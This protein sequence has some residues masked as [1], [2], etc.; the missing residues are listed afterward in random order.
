MFTADADAAVTAAF[1]EH[2]K[3]MSCR[4]FETKM[5]AANRRCHNRFS[6]RFFS[7]LNETTFLR[8][9]LHVSFFYYIVVTSFLNRKY[10]DVRESLVK[11][12]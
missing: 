2:E 8:F 3:W 5:H 10:V 4:V 11:S 6:F 1:D 9:F 7:S 12:S